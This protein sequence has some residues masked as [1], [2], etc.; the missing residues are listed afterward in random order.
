[1]KKIQLGILGTSDVAYRRFMPALLNSPCF[2]Y[3]GVA[4]RCVEKTK[5][6]T[7]A[8]G[9]KG[10]DGYD[11]LL[12]SE[13]VDAVYIP[14]P[15]ALHYEWGKKALESGKHVFMEKPFTLDSQTT[16]ELISL[17]REK[18]LIV[19]ENY[20]FVFHPQIQVIREILQSG[21]IGE[22]RL[23]RT[24][25]GFPFRGVSDFRYNKELGGGALFDC[26]GYPIKLVSSLIGDTVTLTDAHLGFSDGLDVDVYG[27]ATLTGNGVS[28]QIAFGMDNS[29]KCELEIWGS[30]GCLKTDRIF[31][32]P[33][34]YVPVITV[35]V[36]GKVEPISV[37]SSDNFLSSLNAF[38]KEILA[39][40]IDE[41]SSAG[42]LLQSELV[43]KFRHMMGVVF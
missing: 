23:I 25:F 4:S 26:G 1:M 42:I 37:E 3:V 5:K 30:K 11:S 40:K 18:S 12:S 36:D 27:S 21:K 39:G 14:L 17:A 28:A 33:S 8:Y 43:S 10:F 20:M 19:Q 9:G 35:E 34:D 29:Y 13:E 41:S 31:T 32:P 16:A 38:G 2:E 22:I 6:F 7:D 24:A 15:P